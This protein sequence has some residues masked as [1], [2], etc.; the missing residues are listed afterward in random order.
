MTV[1]PSRVHCKR[2]LEKVGAARSNVF[3]GRP[4]SKERMRSTAFESLLPRQA[5]ILP[6]G[7]TEGK[8][9]YESLKRVGSPPE[10]ETLQ[11]CQSRV[12]LWSTH[13]PSGEIAGQFLPPPFVNATGSFPSVCMRQ[14]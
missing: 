4:S 2:L 12:G 9:A 10:S 8:R 11:S 3:S 14:T 5:I 1:F 13:F 7:D 6:S